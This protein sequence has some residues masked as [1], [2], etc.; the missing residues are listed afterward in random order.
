MT[1]AEIRDKCVNVLQNVN[2]SKEE[3][4][5]ILNCF[6]LDRSPGLDGIYPRL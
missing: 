4:L 3:V 6:K 5:T 1:D 2:L